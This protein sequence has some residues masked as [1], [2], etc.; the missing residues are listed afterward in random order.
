MIDHMAREH[1]LEAGFVNEIA[2]DEIVRKVFADREISADFANRILT[3]RDGR[4]QTEFHALQEI[5]DQD[6]RG[7]F[8]GHSNGIESTPDSSSALAAKYTGDG[9]H[10]WIKQRSDHVAQI[11]RS[12]F[13]VAVAGDQNVM[14]GDFRQMME[15]IVGR[16]RPGRLTR[17]QDPAWDVRVSRTNFP[18]DWQ[19]CVVRFVCGKK[20]LVFG[21]VLPKEALDILF[22]PRFVAVYGL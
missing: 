22:H 16:I 2:D 19:R 14:R 17:D 9:P 20:Y 18:D 7:E 8:D 5:G 1:D 3:Q 12:N 11:I 21:I 4:S 10:L 13:N 15:A 6:A